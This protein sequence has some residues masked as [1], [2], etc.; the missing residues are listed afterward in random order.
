MFNFIFGML[1]VVSLILVGGLI[2]GIVKIFKLT[3]RVENVEQTLY[4]EVDDIRRRID[5]ERRKTDSQFQTMSST[6]SNQVV[7][8]ISYVDKRIDKSL[9]S[10][11][12][13][14]K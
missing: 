4:R 12:E 8:T 13:Q 6:M 9:N 3:S 14:K 10:L 5:D 11:K 2:L 1:S 7:E